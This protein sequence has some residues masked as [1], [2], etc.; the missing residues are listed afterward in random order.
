MEER[1]RNDEAGREQEQQVEDGACWTKQR[2]VRQAQLDS[3]TE[4]DL[5]PRGRRT[6]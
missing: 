1:E 2:T 3:Q 6:G 5:R 4:A